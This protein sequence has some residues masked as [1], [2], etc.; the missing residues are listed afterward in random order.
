MPLGTISG[1]GIDKIG[2]FEWRGE[3]D[4]EKGVVKFGRY[5]EHST[6]NL[7]GRRLEHGGQLLR[8]TVPTPKP[9]L[10]SKSMPKVR[11]RGFGSLIKPE[12]NLEDGC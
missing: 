9:K 3:F 5:R 12:G 2:F 1:S 7:H 11:S 8:D 10:N 6:L 4:A